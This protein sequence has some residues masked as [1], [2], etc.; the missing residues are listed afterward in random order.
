MRTYCGINLETREFYI[1]STTQ[2]SRRLTSHEESNRVG[3]KV[4]WLI[5]DE[6]DDPDR[7]EE[8]HY[9]DFYFGMDK[10]LNLSGNAK[11]GNN[12]SV[13]VTDS[14]KQSLSKSAV[15]NTNGSGNRGKRF[16]YD[17]IT[18]ETKRFLPGMEP[19]GWKPGNPNLSKSSGYSIW[20]DENGKQVRVYPGDDTTGLTPPSLKRPDRR[21]EKYN[22]S[23]RKNF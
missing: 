23:R 16:Y 3:E 11:L 2:L 17:P 5:S 14:H 22:Q 1:G 6:H 7:L 9:L 12:N 18:Q 13:I 21:G 10:C 19:D 15:G 8:Q 4:F 20:K